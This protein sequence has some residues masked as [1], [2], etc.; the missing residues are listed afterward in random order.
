[1]S[2][3]HIAS[4]VIYS[5]NVG[6][7]FLKGDSVEIVKES[8]FRSHGDLSNSDDMVRVVLDMSVR[9]WHKTK[10]LLKSDKPTPQSTQCKYSHKAIKEQFD[11]PFIYCPYCSGKL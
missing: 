9:E 8:S 4:N 5:Q 6:L 3:S 7:H 10:Q 2:A 1:M 11:H